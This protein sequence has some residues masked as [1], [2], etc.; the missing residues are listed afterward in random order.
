MKQTSFGLNPFGKSSNKTFITITLAAAVIAITGAVTIYG[1]PA[2]TAQRQT[3]IQVTAGGFVPSTLVIKAGTQ[4]IWRNLDAAPHVVASNPFPGNSSVPGLH[5]KTILPNGSYSYTPT[6]S[7]TIEYHDNI[8]P[9]VG[10]TI[11][12]VR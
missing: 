2:K 1:R 10:G 4:V 8:Q 6:T 5:S 9:I 3:V 12:V 7:G 11:T